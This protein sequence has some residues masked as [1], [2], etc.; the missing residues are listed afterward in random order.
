[1]FDGKDMLKIGDKERRRDSGRKNLH[2]FPGPM[3]SLNPSMKVGDQIV[4]MIRL[5]KVIGKK[6]A[7]EEAC[8]LLE[9]VGIRRERANDYPHQF[10]AA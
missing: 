8:G 1:M 2:D 3:T 9:M 5:H 4:E 6:E 7:F 10:P